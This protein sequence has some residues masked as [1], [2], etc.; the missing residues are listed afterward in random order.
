MF[1]IELML[2]IG[3][4]KKYTYKLMLEVTMQEEK[5]Y[6]GDKHNDLM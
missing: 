4:T 2:G 3:S 5:I 6:K 1:Q